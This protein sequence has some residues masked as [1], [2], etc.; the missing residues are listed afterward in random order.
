MKQKKK[1]H[2]VGKTI[3]IVVLVILLLAGAGYFTYV[4]FQVETI[5]VDGNERY[6][7]SYIEGLANIEPKTHMFFVDTDK[8]AENIEKEPYIHVKEIAKKYPK[9][10]LVTIEERQPKAFV[11]YADKFL[12]VD[13][14]GDVLEIADSTQ[15]SVYPIV[16]GIGI[17]AVNLGKQINTDDQF[18]LAVYTEIITQLEEKALFELI[19]T[20]DLTDINNIKL[21]SRDGMTIKFGQSDKVADKTKWIKKMLPKFIKDGRSNGVLDVSSG[22]DATYRLNDDAAVAPV[23]PPEATQNP[24]EPV[25]SESVQPDVTE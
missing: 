18:K 15:D 25:P 14:Q 11:V 16:S 19:A 22:K 20:I 6:D 24:D 7:S 23:Q 1:Q 12:L 8:I 4:F 9:T 21:T 2:G 5:K 17:D 10:L 3:L 13:Q